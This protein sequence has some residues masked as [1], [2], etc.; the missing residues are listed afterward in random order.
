MNNLKDLSRN[1]QARLSKSTLNSCEAT[2]EEST[3]YNLKLRIVSIFVLLV[4]GLLGA[5]IA[6]VSA[7]IK[8]LHIPLIIINTGKFFGTGVIL[9]TAFIHILPAA[10]N[11]LT[12]EC[13]PEEWK[14]YEAYAGVLIMLAIL[15][16]QLIE[17]VAHH[18]LHSVSIHQI[19][20]VVEETQA[21]PTIIPVESSQQH[22]HSHGLSLLQDSHN[23]RIT[24][25]LLE[26]GIAVHSVLIGVA[27]GTDDGSRFVALFITLCFHQFF[28]AI[29]LGAQISQLNNKSVLPAIFMVIFFALT[30]PVGIAIGI[31]I[32]LN[33]YNPK[34]LAALMTTGV[35]DSVSSGILIYVAL[36]NL[37]A[38]E[39]GAGAHEF[40]RLKKRVKFLY[41]VA[42]YLGATF[43]AIL[44]R[45][46]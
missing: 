16:M 35:L 31:G 2:G 8:R 33:T 1:V 30:T 4:I 7:S 46:V 22:G 34:S 23:H 17:F 41:F 13:L 9:A 36:V 19:K 32:H 5:S 43:M 24:T 3:L 14:N 42:L 44:G 29:A 21:Q 45:W 10:M 39:M 20:V 38:G 37:M 6:V 18:Q 27:L 12:D 25:Y 28:E 15:V 26:F 11:A 40:F